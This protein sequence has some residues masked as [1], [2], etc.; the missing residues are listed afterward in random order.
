MDK[1]TDDKKEKTK[2]TKLAD[3]A[4]TGSGTSVGHSS[5]LTAIDYVTAQT[6][7][8]SAVTNQIN[9]FTSPAY[10]PSILTAFTGVQNSLSGFT[11]VQTL[12][13]N[14][15]HL[16]STSP[17]LDYSRQGTLAISSLSNAASI[18]GI[19]TSVGT[20]YTSWYEQNI[21]KSSI[22][23]T[24]SYSPLTTA[25]TANS[26]VGVIGTQSL[27]AFTFQSGIVKATEF[28]LFAEKSLCSI[29]SSNLGS[30]LTLG[31]ETKDF[32]STTFTGLSNS[33][34]GLLRSFESNPA[35]Y[36]LL[37]P[38]L[39]R[40]APIEYFSSANLL[41]AISVE[42]E[43]LPEEELL[44]NE[45]VYE[46]EIQLSQ[47]LPKIDPGLYKM[48]KGAIESYNSN[49]SDKVRHFSASIRE[50]YTHLMHKLAP[51]SEI[52]K[53]SE[54][55]QY[56]HEGRPTRKARLLYI[57]RNINN[58]PFNTFVK[59]DV[60][61]MLAFIDIFQKGTHDI[62]PYFSPNHLVTIKSKA[63]NTLKFLLEIHYATNK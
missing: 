45:L 38:T 4:I 44:K 62:D 24:S 34:S 5:Y 47:Y 28:S 58:D 23:A 26:L 1:K 59:K 13:P 22:L 12:L 51:D 21:A 39:S 46:N 16:V 57:C 42:E 10:Q 18:S 3:I 30:R 55:A 40:M 14:V 63:E 32:L 56:Y 20:N 8:L 36:G 61:A 37:G 25:A 35:S 33:Y 17:I 15:S 50:L 41:E 48:W 11:T 27:S 2:A 53:W 49:N 60:D 52:K 29:T 43:T 9:L 31:G 7:R 6:S 54:D 19:A